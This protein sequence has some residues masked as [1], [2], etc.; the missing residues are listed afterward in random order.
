MAG[1]TLR[2]SPSE[3][4]VKVVRAASVVAAEESIEG[5]VGWGGGGNVLNLNTRVQ[6]TTVYASM[7]V[8]TCKCI[9]AYCTSTDLSEEAPPC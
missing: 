1:R 2:V 3:R 4:E 9:T 6:Y 7:F 8:C 5:G